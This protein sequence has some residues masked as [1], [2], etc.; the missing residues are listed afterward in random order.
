MS[1]AQ[2]GDEAFTADGAPYARGDRVRATSPEGET[3]VVRVERVVAI[4]TGGF[5]VIGAVTSPRR[6]RS[7]LLTMVV[8]AEGNGPSISPLA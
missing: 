6:F 8:D 1:S 2:I 7:Q 4:P 3:Y 5:H